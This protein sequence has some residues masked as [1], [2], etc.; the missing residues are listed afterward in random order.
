MKGSESMNE[1]VT[2]MRN[3]AV[4]SSLQIAEH[5]GKQ[6]KVV[7]RAIENAISTGHNFG[8][9]E[10]PFRKS[11][12]KDESGKKNPM[13]YLTRDGFSFVVMGFTGKKAAEWKWKYI[14]AFNAM[15]KVI[16][17][18]L[19]LEWQHTRAAGKLTRKAETDVI[20]LLAEYAKGQGSKNAQ[21]LYM[22]YSRLANKAVGVTSRETASIRELNRLEE[23]EEM[24]LKVIRRDMAQDVHYKEI[25]QN[26]KRQLEAWQEILM[27][28]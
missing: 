2:L 1:L 6:H 15:E 3:D 4:V 22:V 9:S 26:C 10:S 11:H 8:L 20:K 21:K 14:A 24:I 18:R 12:Y 17:E 7:L 25:Y 27:V 13:Y 5:F 19:T 28:A 23:V 16:R